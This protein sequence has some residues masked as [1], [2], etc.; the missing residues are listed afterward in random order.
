MSDI[1][2]QILIAVASGL[3]LMLLASIGTGMVWLVRK[4]IKVDRDV[5]CAHDKLR[6][7]GDRISDLEETN[8]SRE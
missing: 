3:V 4:A 5:D 2:S 1:T 6:E 7:H 8:F